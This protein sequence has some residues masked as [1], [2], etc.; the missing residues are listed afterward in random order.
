MIFSDPAHTAY[1]FWD[2]RLL[3][4]YY[5]AQDFTR[6]GMPVWWDESVDV[7]FEVKRKV[8]R[9]RAAVE[10]AQAADSKRKAKGEGVYYVPVP[11]GLGGK[12]MPTFE[13]WAEEQ[14][15]LA[16]KPKFT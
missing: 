13:E 12:P 8:S 14:S 10:R 3:Q 9:S 2:L 5:F 7:N 15:R 11:K 16:G 4:A 6:D 1:D